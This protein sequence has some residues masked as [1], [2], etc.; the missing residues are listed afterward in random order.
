M[1]IFPLNFI[2]RPP[3]PH[4][5]EPEL[6]QNWKLNR[7]LSKCDFVR[8]VLQTSQSVPPTEGRHQSYQVPEGE[9]EGDPHKG[10]DEAEEKEPNVQFLFPS[11]SQTQTT[12]CINFA[13][14]TGRLYSHVLRGE[15]LWW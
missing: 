6:L 10:E 8:P 15:F 2:Y 7:N 5:P 14:F 3:S 4:C 1:F 13:S 12:S 9:G 11:S